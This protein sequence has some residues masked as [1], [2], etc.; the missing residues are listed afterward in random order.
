MKRYAIYFAPPNGALATAGAGWLGRNA[1]SGDRLPQPDPALPDLTVAPQRYGFHATLKAPFRLT[2]TESPESLHAG[3]GAL[4]ATLRPVVLEGLSVQVFHGSI[5]LLPVGP[6][7]AL[8]ALAAEVVM[9]LDRFRAPL[10]ASDIA[11]R[12]PAALTERQRA[13][14]EAWGYP[15]VLDKFRFHMT[16]T[17]RLT[18]DQASVLLPLAQAHFADALRGPV[19]IDA[20][21]LFA[22][23]EIGVFHQLDHFPLG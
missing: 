12:N 4:A 5:A 2:A 6:T 15:L 23:D 10:S 13:L 9:R 19:A 7:A 1:V 14:M 18:A 20:L 3:I 11:R 21:A 22:E 8:D 17:D 16:L